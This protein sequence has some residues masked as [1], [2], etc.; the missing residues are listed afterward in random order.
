MLNLKGFREVCRV[1]PLVPNQVRE[2]VEGYEIG[3]F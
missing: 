1:D 3:C 2:L